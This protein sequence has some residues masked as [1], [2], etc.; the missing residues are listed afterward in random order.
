MNGGALHFPSFP[1]PEPPRLPPASKD[2]PAPN[3][4]LTI[5][6]DT[7]FTFMVILHVFISSYCRQLILSLEGPHKSSSL[8]PSPILCFQSLPNCPSRNC[9]VFTFMQN[10]G[11]CT[12]L[13]LLDSLLVTVRRS[14]PTRS[15]FF[16]INTS[17]SVPKQRALTAFRMN[18]YEGNNILDSVWR[19][20]YDLSCEERHEK[21]KNSPAS[22]RSLLE[23][24]QLSGLHGCATLA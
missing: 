2:Y 8:R 4:P 21:A 11:G 6:L 14:L 9:F 18:T 16:R 5:L 1:L 24:R 13:P 22:D 23:S 17:K 12:P 10:D 3:K 15:N 7:P 20:C 19:F